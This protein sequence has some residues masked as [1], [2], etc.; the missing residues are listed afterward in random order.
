MQTYGFTVSRH[1]FTD[2]DGSSH[3]NLINLNAYLNFSKWRI[4]YSPR[5][6]SSILV[7]RKLSGKDPNEE[8]KKLFQRFDRRGK[9]IIDSQSLLEVCTEVNVDISPVDLHCMLKEF[10]EDMDGG[11]NFDEFSRVIQGARALKKY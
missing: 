4:K 3:S 1:E 10:D 5:P 11:L 7:S 9:G 6:S 8:L 2:F